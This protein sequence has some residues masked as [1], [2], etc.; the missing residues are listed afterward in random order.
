M[1]KILKIFNESYKNGQQINSKNVNPEILDIPKEQF[2][3]TMRSLSEEGY[4]SGVKV[5]TFYDGETDVFLKAR[6]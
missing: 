4:I 2:Y 5:Q 6:I 3:Q 1:K